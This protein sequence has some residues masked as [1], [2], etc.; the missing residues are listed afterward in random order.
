MH[1]RRR[2]EPAGGVIPPLMKK[3]MFPLIGG[4]PRCSCRADAENVSTEVTF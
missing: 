3:K 4:T 1:Y 2:G